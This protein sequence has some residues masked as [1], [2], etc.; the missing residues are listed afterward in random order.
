MQRPVAGHTPEDH[1]VY[2]LKDDLF[3]HQVLKGP[4]T[5]VQTRYEAS[6]FGDCPR[7]E[8]PM[9][10]V[11]RCLVLV[12]L[13]LICHSFQGRTVHRRSRW[14]AIDCAALEPFRHLSHNLLK[15]FSSWV[16]MRSPS[17]SQTPTIHSHV[18]FEFTLSSMRS[19]TR[20]KIALRPECVASDL[21]TSQ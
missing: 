8:R 19:I 17:G 10:W 20:N 6:S 5:N 13:S 3:I 15:V 7:V 9:S 4:N 21:E 14:I 12:I 2:D 1:Y 16:S 11:W 18:V